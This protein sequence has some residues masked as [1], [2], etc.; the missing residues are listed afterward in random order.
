MNVFSR[1][2]SLHYRDRDSIRKAEADLDMPSYLND[3]TVR[4]SLLEGYDES[5]HD[6]AN[7]RQFDGLN[8]FTV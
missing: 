3:D 2:F 5:A 6:Y 1:K 8:E 7:T 4:M